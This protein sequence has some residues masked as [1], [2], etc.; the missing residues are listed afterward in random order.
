MSDEIRIPAYFSHSYRPGDREVN[1]FFWSLFWES[2]FTF[3]VDP[4]SPTLSIPH[5]ELMMR[6]SA[7]FVAVVTH[8]PQQAYY[9]SSPFI[10]YEYG[11]AVRAQK[12]RLIFVEAGVPGQ[13]FSESAVTIAFDRRRLEE[14]REGFRDLIKQLADQSRAYSNLAD[15]Q[16]GPAGLLLPQNSQY[17]EAKGAI[18]KLLSAA[19]HE[20]REIVTG[21]DNSFQFALRLDE[22]DFILIDVGSKSIPTWVYPFLHGRF[23]PT[24]RLMHQATADDRKAAPVLDNDDA[25]TAAGVMDEVVIHW[26]T[27]D[28]LITQLERQVEKLFQLRRPFLSEEEGL[29]YL[30]SLGRRKESIFISNAGEDNNFASGLV[31]A[32]NLQNILPFH[33][34]YENQ[35]TLGKDW[36][37]ELKERVRSS[38]LFVPLI[39]E[40][41]W[42]SE[43][44][45]EE[46]EIARHLEG[47]GLLTMY[48]YFLDDSKQPQ[49]PAHGRKLSHLSE[50]VGI[51][52]IVDDV[53]GYLTSEREGEATAGVRSSGTASRASWRSSTRKVSIDIAIMTVLPEEYA[54]VYACLE[55]P[56]RVAGRR[57]HPNDYSWV[58]GEIQSDEHKAPYR[59]VLGLAGRPGEGSGLRAVKDTIDAFSTEYLLLVGIAGGL[60]DVR[61]GDVVL[62]DHIYGYEYGK[63]DEGFKPR[64][65]WIF[66]TEIGMFNAAQTLEFINPEWSEAIGLKAPDGTRSPKIYSGPVASGNKVIDDVSDPSFKPV[67]D[68]WPKLVAVEMEALGAAE[69]IEWAKQKGLA[70]Q[71]SMVRGISDL[72]PVMPSQP[73]SEDDGQKS[74]QTQE[75]D[76]W[77]KYAAEAAAVLATQ[78]IRRSWRVPPRNL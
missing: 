58:F 28:E 53:D 23:I 7:C 26:S 20:P 38:Q 43:W 65:D 12:P 61:R 71:F 49:V 27:S 16:R 31:R 15:R 3:A 9:K 33:Y 35:L 25:L 11:L 55:D 44:C 39:S 66:H 46:Y 64:P 60:R 50:E 70:V 4:E 22:C 6:W 48:P 24:V 67:L 37:E 45:K 14:R 29:R 59:I 19:G 73:D 40:A 62:S 41:Y 54:A 17:R 52:Q 13:Y 51:K 78:I 36:H 1:E 30:R 2:G 10:V 56:S 75:R 72:P 57:G 32:L 18:A 8:R 34:V 76:L 63:V 21:F 69:A 42:E 5:L 47:Q 77:K 74:K 68:F